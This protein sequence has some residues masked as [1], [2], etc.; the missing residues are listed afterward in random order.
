MMVESQQNAVEHA[1]KLLNNTS[2]STRQREAAQR[3]LVA[4][5]HPVFI[6][7][8]AKTQ[9]RKKYLL[10]KQ[11][12]RLTALESNADASKLAS[13]RAKLEE[14][15]Q[16][17]L[18]RDPNVNRMSGQAVLESDDT[19]DS[20][21]L[22]RQQLF[23]IIGVRMKSRHFELMCRQMCDRG[24]YVDG[25]GKMSMVRATELGFYV[26]PVI[27]NPRKNGER[28]ETKAVMA[29]AYVV[30]K[31][32]I[33]VWKAVIQ[34]FK[35]EFT[36]A[37]ANENAT[38]AFV[39]MDKDA[40]CR[41]ALQTLWPGVP[42]YLCD[43]H[44]GKALMEWLNKNRFK[45]QV[46][47]KQCLLYAFRRMKRASSQA[48][49]EDFEQKFTV[50]ALQVEFPTLQTLGEETKEF[51]NYIKKEWLCEAWRRS[52]PSYVRKGSAHNTNIVAENGWRQEQTFEYQ[53]RL[54]RSLEQQLLTCTAM[55][56]RQ[57][58]QLLGWEAHGFDPAPKTREERMEEKNMRTG[59]LFSRLLNFEMRQGSDSF[60]HETAEY[61]LWEKTTSSKE[62][63]VVRRQLEDVEG[64]DVVRY[65]CSCSFWVVH[66]HICPHIAAVRVQNREQAEIRLTRNDLGIVH[67]ELVSHRTQSLPEWGSLISFQHQ[68][69]T[70]EIG[71]RH[72]HESLHPN[73]KRGPKKQKV[74]EWFPFVRFNVD[75]RALP[76]DVRNL[77]FGTG[78][79]DVFGV[80]HGFLGGEI[81]VDIL[82]VQGSEERHI[83]RTVIKHSAVDVR[84]TV[85]SNT[86]DLNRFV[87]TLLEEYASRSVQTSH[88]EVTATGEERDIPC[89]TSMMC[90]TILEYGLTAQHRN[91]PLKAP[92]YQAT[93][94][95]HTFKNT[96][97]L[98]TPLWL[99]TC[100]IGSDLTLMEMVTSSERQ[101]DSMLTAM[102]RKFAA[103]DVYTVCKNWYGDIGA[104]D[105]ATTFSREVQQ[106]CQ[107]ATSD[108]IFCES[109]EVFFSLL[110]A[111]R[112]VLFNPRESVDVSTG[113]GNGTS[114]GKFEDFETFADDWVTAT[115]QHGFTHII[116]REKC[117]RVIDAYTKSA[118][119]CAVDLDPDALLFSVG[120]SPLTQKV[121]EH[122]QQH[123]LREAARDVNNLH[124]ADRLRE[125]RLGGISHR[126]VPQ[127][128]ILDNGKQAE[129]AGVILNGCQS[130]EAHYVG[131][132]LI[133]DNTVC[134]CGV[135]AGWYFYDSAKTDLHMRMHAVGSLEEYGRDDADFVP[136]DAIDVEAYDVCTL[137]YRQVQPSNGHGSAADNHSLNE[138]SSMA[139]DAI[140]DNE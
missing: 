129:L 76:D 99:L 46:L 45:N 109:D 21:A 50:E 8:L 102:M 112:C 91:A 125:Q 23:W 124:E 132:V 66:G 98:L 7:T 37:L 83:A 30:S 79:A 118:L 93:R 40:E 77:L 123:I 80:F 1:D 120:T 69:M 95:G 16:L 82:E 107:R 85:T 56:S 74:F 4:A 3:I 49:F 63:T 59:M 61:V 25:C 60:G 84:H 17:T 62:A 6:S 88:D 137:L 119:S 97:A 2:S 122:L 126:D 43:W 130:I 110:M 133:T 24:I 10:M 113:A 26:K 41:E 44:E 94:D 117:A 14:D 20:T 13:V 139:E 115:Q 64:S 54:R 78:K 48:E 67:G 34:S 116:T 39:M 51:V 86:R 72:V 81:V 52:W 140:H 103:G 15:G 9:R 90:K 47:G 92:H 53:N 55:M 42:L 128:I 114:V 101:G 96:C 121:R 32:T 19:V 70:H 12:A 106:V 38:P 18:W 28:M 138:Q 87:E 27:S 65:S 105:P 89:D 104:Q 35:K 136:A 58:L 22:S 68:L 29:A 57:A 33:P 100:I 127:R 131:F 134:D 73:G 111:K 36:N 108:M 5:Q 75:H 31:V 11:S 71:H 135:A